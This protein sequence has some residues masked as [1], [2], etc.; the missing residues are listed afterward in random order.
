MKFL[1]KTYNT[2]GESDTVIRGK[3]SS[4]KKGEGD[5]SGVGE[6]KITGE[7]RATVATSPPRFG[8][9]SAA[10][11]PSV[12]NAYCSAPISAV[13]IPRESHLSSA[14]YRFSVRYRGELR[15]IPSRWS[16]GQ[17]NNAICKCIRRR[18]RSL[19]NSDRLSSAP[20]MWERT[21]I[22]RRRRQARKGQ[23]KIRRYFYRNANEAINETGVA[24]HL[25]EIHSVVGVSTTT[26]FVLGKIVA[27]FE[28]LRSLFSKREGDDRKNYR[29]LGIKLSERIVRMHAIYLQR[30]SERSRVK[31]STSA[32]SFW[33][34]R[35]RGIRTFLFLLLTPSL[36][37]S[38]KL[39]KNL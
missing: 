25:R 27:R 34:T 18:P 33:K 35:Y 12:N 16:L 23:K 32:D 13:F 7:K 11:A 1:I 14:P 22:A 19:E 3:R 9:R 30:C 39:I 2:F 5:F 24:M 37:L 4:R 17:D 10:Q 20:P 38:G 29:D 6:M 15:P 36:S 8:T 21:K 26:S 28:M 31:T